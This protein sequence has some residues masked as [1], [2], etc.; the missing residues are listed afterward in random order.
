MELD[1]VNATNDVLRSSSTITYGGTLS[2]V[3]LGGPLS[4][5]SSFKLFNASSYLGTFSSITPS[6]PGPGQT[7]D[8]SALGTSG[9]LKVINTSA[10][11]LNFG[12]TNGVIT[13]S[14]PNGYKLVWQT[15]SLSTGLGTNWIDY[16]ITGS[17][18]NVIVS[19]S[20]PTAFFGLKPQ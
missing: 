1:E 12:I 3:N 4:G 15:N 20:I 8:T 14:W 13:F 11:N 18:V 17:P 9:T 16:P 7:W 10:P 5:G 2:L 19:P 6:T